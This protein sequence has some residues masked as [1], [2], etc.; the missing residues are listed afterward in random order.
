MTAAPIRIVL[1]D[2]HP[3]YRDG[4]GVLLGSLPGLEVV[5]VAGDG[6]EAVAVVE[7]V[8]P[9]V[10]VM[11]I[12]M[13][14]LDGIAA[15]RRLLE[16]R[17]D[18][19]ILLLTMSEDDETV[20][21]GL[22]AGARGFVLKGADQ[23]D[24]SRA[25]RAVAGGDAILGSGLA[26]RIAGYVEAAAAGAAGAAPFPELTP[27]ER[28]ILDHIAAGRSNGQ[29]AAS[30]YLSPKTVSNN[31]SSIFAKLHVEGRAEAIVKA[32]EAGLGRL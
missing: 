1:V 30:L 2:D 4:L 29:I 25:I 32:R 17:P 22:R 7:D 6:A 10:V 27:R 8:A 3:V 15:T 11:D 20:F 19:G 12:A 16:D 23:D 5:G 18:L 9:D 24:I 13:P 26:N 14:V 31:I 21:D 28:E